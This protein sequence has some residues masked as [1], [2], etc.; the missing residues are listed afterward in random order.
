MTLDQL[1][2]ILLSYPDV[3]EAP[4]YGTPGFRVRKKLLARINDK[5]NALV[6]KV[7]D[8]D[9]QEALIL[10][11]PRVFFTTPHYEGHPYVL[12]RMNKVRRADI[13]EVFEAAWRATAS[14]K[15]VAAFDQQ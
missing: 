11:N 14:K 3:Q 8:L 6:L 5:E 13:E 7:A 12:A 15:T 10:A 2:K 1:R 4:S 9:E